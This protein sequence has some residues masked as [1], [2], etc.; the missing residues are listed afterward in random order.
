MWSLRPPAYVNE[1]EKRLQRRYDAFFADPV[2]AAFVGGSGYAN[3]GYWDDGTTAGHAACDALVDRLLAGMPRPPRAVLDV[4]CGQGATTRRIAQVTLAPRVVG[5]DLALPRLAAAR[6]RGVQHVARMNAVELGFADGAFDAVVSVEA[7]FHFVTRE[8][9]LRE[10]RRVLAPGGVLLL[11]DV[12]ATTPAGRVPAENLLR[13]ADAYRALLARAGFGGCRVDDVTA[14]TWKAFR[15]RY[16]G[17]VLRRLLTPRVLARLPALCWLAL[18]RL[19]ATERALARYVLVTA[20]K[21]GRAT[22]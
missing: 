18:T 3:Y 21:D 17:F 4:A 22:G 20:T 8:A 5:V 1:L 2:F 14:R 12:I 10:A 7:A 6:A 13:D 9:F 15:R 19:P 16:A 11:A